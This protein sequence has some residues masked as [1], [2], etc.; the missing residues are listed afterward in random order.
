MKRILLSS[1]L[2]MVFA[3]LPSFGG[4]GHK[5][6]KG[7]KHHKEEQAHTCEKCKKDE[8][9]CKCHDEDK[10][11]KEQEASNNEVKK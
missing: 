10:P 3:A 2:M 11:K 4:K 1:V 8:K 7:E 5:H 9:D 6:A